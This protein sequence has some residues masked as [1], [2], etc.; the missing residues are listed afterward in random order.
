[1]HQPAA[2]PA[3]VDY[4]FSD[5]RPMAES[6]FQL[7][8]LLYALTALRTHFHRHERVYVAG[9]MFVYFKEGDPGAVVAPDVFVVLGAPKHDR[10]SYKLWEEPKAPDFVL[11][12]LS[13]SSHKTDLGRK[14]RVYASLGVAEYWQLDP[15]GE[16]L[17]PPL[18]G[19][20]LHGR[21][22]RALPRVAMISGGTSLHSAVLGL[23]VRLDAQGE[24]RLH[25][26][27]T[28]ED[29]P[30]HREQQTRIE[31]EIAARRAAE[32]RAEKEAEARRAAQ[33][34]AE[35]ETEARRA[36]EARL[37]EEATAREAEAE[38]RRAA[39]ARLAELEARLARAP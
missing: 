12:I 1:M 28:G 8:P 13:R 26:P 9:D 6:D 17:A 25:D 11:E 10:L 39:E 34:Q 37:R 32:A 16:H 3:T 29:L 2:L 31:E 38:A 35:K 20:R 21:R 18:R 7:K 5:G 36:A 33:I 19:L 15:T 14:R 23:D 4:P 30:A 22:Y 24:L 27:H